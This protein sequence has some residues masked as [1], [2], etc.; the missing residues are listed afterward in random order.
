MS[1][2]KRYLTINAIAENKAK[3]YAKAEKA[4]LEH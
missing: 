2:S 3:E 1:F 4:T